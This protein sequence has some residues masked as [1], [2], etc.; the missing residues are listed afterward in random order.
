MGVKSSEVDLLSMKVI[1]SLAYVIEQIFVLVELRV[2]DFCWI[3]AYG[4]IN[5]TKARVLV[6]ILARRT[7]DSLSFKLFDFEVGLVHS[8]T[9]LFEVLE[10]L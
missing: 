2:W 8:A 7:P 5:E 6:C 4:H 9:E 1:Q 3:L 10:V